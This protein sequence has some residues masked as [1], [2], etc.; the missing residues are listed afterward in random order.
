[1]RRVA[2]HRAEGEHDQGSRRLGGD[3]VF[4]GGEDQPSSLDVLKE[5]IQ[6]GCLAFVSRSMLGGHPGVTESPEA[7]GPLRFGHENLEPGVAAEGVE[8]RVIVN[9]VYD[10]ESVCPPAPPQVIEGSG[11]VT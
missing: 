11:G 4:D 9:V 10:L 5:P 7:P 3:G 1:M 8:H 2:A 6:A